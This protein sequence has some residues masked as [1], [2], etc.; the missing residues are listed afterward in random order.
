MSYGC[1]F[2]ADC[3]ACGAVGARMYVCGKDVWCS[4]CHTEVGEE[5]RAHGL[6]FGA[7]AEKA[8]SRG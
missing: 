1:I 8:A 2:V 6:D 5:R 7:R 4:R 3:P